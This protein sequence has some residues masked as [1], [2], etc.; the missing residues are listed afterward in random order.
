M[1]RDRPAFTLME[2]MVS[3]V[4]I[5]VVVLGIVMIRHQNSALMEFITKR[6]KGE[7][8]NSL[9]LGPSVM[10]YNGDTKDALTLLKRMNVND[11]EAR[12]ILEGEK[13]LIHVSAPLPVDPPTSPFGLRAI[14]LKGD[15]SARYYRVIR[16]APVAGTKR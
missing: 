5:S 11:I 2:V 13:R 9:F 12:R 16:Q 6:I 10:Q 8:A 14:M 4:L 1:K 3:V 15:F 7:F